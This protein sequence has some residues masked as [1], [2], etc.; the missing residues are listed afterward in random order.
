MKVNG[1]DAGHCRISKA[2]QLKK[3]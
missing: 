2:F 1:S 3:I